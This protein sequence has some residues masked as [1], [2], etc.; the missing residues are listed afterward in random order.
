MKP[1]HRRLANAIISPALLLAL[2]SACIGFGT[3]EDGYVP[4]LDEPYCVGVPE[5]LDRYCSECHG[6]IPA[7]AAPA[8][9][10]TD[11]L[12]DTD[13]P[14]ASSY[15]SRI[16]ARAVFTSGFPMPPRNHEVQPTQAELD[17]LDD[18]IQDGATDCADSNQ[19]GQVG[20]AR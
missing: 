1:A 10:R 5:I 6:E 18:W 11:V 19:N 20:G 15:A 2:C 17:Y 3:Q 4:P 9:F 8:T 13:V 14:G 7:N 12:I 16:R